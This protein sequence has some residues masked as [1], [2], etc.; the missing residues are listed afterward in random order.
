M[1]LLK[2]KQEVAKVG[3]KL[4]ELKTSPVDTIVVYTQATDGTLQ[5]KRIEIKGR[6]M[7]IAIES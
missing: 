7:A 3:Y 5:I 6:K 1:I 2:G 4:T